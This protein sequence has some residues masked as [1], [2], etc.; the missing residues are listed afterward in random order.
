MI[1]MLN[2]GKGEMDGL[3]EIEVNRE[4]ELSLYH[5]Y[6]DGNWEYY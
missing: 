6:K 1:S 3:A 4:L 5:Y 2:F